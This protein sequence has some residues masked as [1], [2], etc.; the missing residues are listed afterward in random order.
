MANKIDV[1]YK[2]GTT[3]YQTKLEYKGFSKWDSYSSKKT[4]LLS[5]SR[6]KGTKDIDWVKLP[7][8]VYLAWEKRPQHFH[9]FKAGV[10]NPL[11]EFH[12]VDGY[13]GPLYT[14]TSYFHRRETLYGRDFSTEAR[15]DLKR[16]SRF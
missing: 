16:V 3:S 6:D 8:L 7:T 1:A 2:A 4:M 11:V 5:C 12:D 10:M 14:G 9:N 15:I 13:G